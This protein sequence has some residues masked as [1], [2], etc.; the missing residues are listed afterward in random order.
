MVDNSGKHAV[1][2][3]TDAEKQGMGFCHCHSN[4]FNCHAFIP[5]VAGAVLF[6]C[7]RLSQSSLEPGLQIGCA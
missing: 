1:V 6:V 4:K 7:S 3:V 2:M 5:R